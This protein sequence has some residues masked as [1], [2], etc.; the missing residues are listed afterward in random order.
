MKIMVKIWRDLRNNLAQAYYTRD[1]STKVRELRDLVQ[2]L[3][4]G[5]NGRKQKCRALDA[6]STFM[7]H[8]RWGEGI[9]KGE[10]I[11]ENGSDRA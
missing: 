10:S 9:R 1:D 2:F 11:L 4:M 7:H 3:Y 6:H 5:S 8:M